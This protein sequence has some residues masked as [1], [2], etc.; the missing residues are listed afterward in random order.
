MPRATVKQDSQENRLDDA[1]F[2]D[3]E[4]VSS[5]FGTKIVWGKNEK[6][7]E[8]ET[9]VGTFLGVRIV[10]LGD[11]D[12]EGNVLD[13]AEA[14]EFADMNGERFYSWL[15]YA[16]KSAIEDETIIPN[17]VVRIH[18]TGETATKRG[19]NP[20]KTFDIKRKPR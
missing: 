5:D 8:T 14:A 12:S 11:A 17:D 13:T 2:D 6:A 18:Y 1:S 9:F 4:T 15:P 10:P 7:G 19:L 16:L 3:W 20:V